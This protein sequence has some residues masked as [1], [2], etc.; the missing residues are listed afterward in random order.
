MENLLKAIL[1]GTD[2]AE[3]DELLHQLANT[4]RQYFLRNEILQIFSKLCDQLEK[5]K[6]FFY[7]SVLGQLLHLTHEMLIDQGECWFL[8]RPS[9]AQQW[10]Y[11][12]NFN[13][14]TCDL[15]S[16]S[17]LLDR[18][19]RIVHCQDSDTFEIN[20]EPFFNSE[21]TIDDPRNVGKSFKFLHQFLVNKHSHKQTE[22]EEIL[23][24]KIHQSR[25]ENH[26]FLISSDI[27][28]LGQLQQVLAPAYECLNQFQD[29]DSSL[30]ILDKFKALGLEPGWG[31]TIGRCRATLKLLERLIQYPDACTLEAFLNKIPN[32]F[33]VVSISV[34]GW[35][36]QDNVLGKAETA[37]QVAYVL[38]QAKTLEKKLIETIDLAGLSHLNLEPQVI[39]LTRLIPECEGTHCNTKLE[40]IQGTQFAKILRI[41]FRDQKGQIVSQWISKFHIWPYLR[42]FAEEACAEVKNLLKYRKPDLLIGHYSDGNLVA[43]RMAKKLKTLHCNIAHSLE[44]TKHL[45]GDLYWHKLEEEYNFSSQFA[46]DL[47]TM[48]S[49]DFIV[50][51]SQ[52]EIFGNHDILGQYESYQCFTL[53]NLFHVVNG[54]N[55]RSSKFAIVP[56]GV[57]QQI[58]YPYH[59][60]Q[61]AEERTQAIENLLFHSADASC[62]G[63]LKNPNLRPLLT[64]AP[65]QTVKNL[66][67]LVEAFGEH[68]ELKEHCNLILLTG[69]NQRDEA[70]NPEQIQI[71][72]RLH[73]LIKSYG[74]ESNIRWIGKR[75]PSEDLGELYRVI[76]DHHG[77]LMHCVHF[78]AFGL[79]LLEAMISG[80]PTI[81]T[82]FGG[83][84]EIVIPGQN[85]LLVNP[86]NMKEALDQVLDLVTQ[87]EASD[88]HWEKFSESSIH[89]I[90]NH[91][92]WDN[93]VNQLLTLTKIHKYLK[94]ENQ[95]QQAAL[96]Q[97]LEALY[98]LIYQNESPRSNNEPPR[99][100]DPSRDPQLSST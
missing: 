36:G 45:F 47:I 100:P 24:Q 91:Y 57:D 7:S 75:L 1:Q 15:M 74:L 68:P 71:I 99:S 41:P 42:T 65:L 44:K 9:V 88:K 84:A 35:F 97:Y 87:F 82:K 52:H 38:D 25:F 5:P 49:S 14:Q 50:T 39:I 31:N 20:F 16:P 63:H 40:H 98:R 6:Y 48:N 12:L 73:K 10:V 34:H 54:V 3:L 56:P 28:N 72:K 32:L 89:H 78:E 77:I 86:S 55:L 23:F 33:S 22:W 13:D 11:R 70:Q 26:S 53:P 92:Q 66:T 46:A 61:R 85:G 83:A 19:D 59:S 80:L 51:A 79:T 21:L 69:I 37:G 95:A 81:T 18:R 43:Y 58:F 62:I 60:E 90:Q 94:Q 17:D 30:L 76:A 96:H 67:G 29:E 8:L 4:K 2:K 27:K 93:H 64:F